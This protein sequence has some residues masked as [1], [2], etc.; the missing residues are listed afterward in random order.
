MS[1]YETTFIVNPQSDDA[2]L[3]QHVQAVTSII[4]NNGGQILRENRMGTRRLAYEIRN[5]TQGYYTS[6]IFDAPSTVLPILER[7]FKLEE[8]YIRHLTI[9]FDGPIPS[10]EERPAEQE[11]PKEKPEQPERP[12]GTT[13]GRRPTHEPESSAEPTEEVKEE[14]AEAEAE[15]EPE[16]E[17]PA[18]ENVPVV[19]ESVEK[20][21]EPEKAEEEPR[22]Q[23]P[24]EDEI[25]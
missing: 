21:A 12:A 1:I 2:S 6:M 15:A 3:D 10:E 20:A 4:T 17:K 23:T 14:A 19:D 9:R 11:A 25:L 18:E 7:H 5:L 24:S 16:A 13:V 8:Q 22:R